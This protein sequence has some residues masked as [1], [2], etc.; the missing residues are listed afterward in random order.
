MLTGCQ[1]V[2][3]PQRHNLSQTG[4]RRSFLT[5][6]PARVSGFSKKLLTLTHYQA[7]QCQKWTPNV[8]QKRFFGGTKPYLPIRLNSYGHVSGRVNFVN[9]L[10]L[11]LSFTLLA[12]IGLPV[13]RRRV[14]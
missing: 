7:A 14:H 13:F 1:S 5:C 9:L 11:S 2:M 8:F 6:V 4:S 10:T 12:V 3:N